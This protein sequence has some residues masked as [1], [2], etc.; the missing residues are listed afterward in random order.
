MIVRESKTGIPLTQEEKEI[1][2]INSVINGKIYVPFVPQDASWAA[3][4]SPGGELW[5]D[6]NGL[7]ALSKKQA[8][9][10]KEWRRCDHVVPNPVI[11]HQVSPRNVTQTCVSDCS[12]VSAMIL[13]AGFERKFNKK[14]ITCSIFPQENG[15]PVINP[16]GKYC[17]RLHINGCWR[18]ILIDTHLPYGS[19][20]RKLCSYSADHSELWVSLIEKA[21]MKVWDLL[22]YSFF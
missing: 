18:R 7:L 17:I 2:K 22:H 21:Y 8:G 3:L 5:T 1:I 6:P 20:D 14:L 4:Y 12:F 13:S 11:F 10:F 19:H 9:R 16:S 15:K